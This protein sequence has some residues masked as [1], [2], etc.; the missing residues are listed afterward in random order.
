MTNK[1]ILITGGSGFV[2][3]NL[4]EY[5]INSGWDVFSLDIHH[6]RNNAHMP[7]WNKIDLLDRQAIFHALKDFS[8]NIILHFG[9][10]TDLDERVNL[11]GYAA[12]IEGTWNLIDGIRETTSVE[13]I[14]FASSQL[15]CRL[16]YKPTN[17]E[18]YAPSTFYGLSKIWMERIIRTANLDQ[19]WMIVRPTSFWGPWFG[20][21]Y[22]N[23]FDVVKKGLFIHPAN[24]IVLKQWGYIGN[25]IY[26]VQRLLDADRE[27]IHG[28]TFYLADHQPFDLH[29]FA[30]VVSKAF[31]KGNVR[32]V[33]LKLLDFIAKSGDFLQ[34]I[35][36]T[37]PPLTSFRLN[38]IIT[39]EVQDLSALEE[40]VGE[41]PYDYN[42]GIQH[43][44]KWMQEHAP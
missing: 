15:V 2:G 22:R 25:S 12:N 29:E 27:Q 21:P 3:T 10:R 14:I 13:R 20:I 38:N 41:L 43:T 40:I 30:N 9:A 36:W 31:G 34:R 18:D 28:K 7:H 19:T 39:E 42:Q 37:S 17:D 11:G 23:F 16:G 4:V 44:I 32:T 1:K 33:P 5:Y 35:G 6:P 8:P 24:L 26:Q